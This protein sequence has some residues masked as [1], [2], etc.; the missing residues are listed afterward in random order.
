MK[1]NTIRGESGQEC[2]KDEL[3]QTILK[4]R[5]KIGLLIEVENIEK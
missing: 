1:N 4:G 5:R 3:N 2:G